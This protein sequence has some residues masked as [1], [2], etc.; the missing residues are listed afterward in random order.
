MTPCSDRQPS[1]TSVCIHVDLMLLEN[2]QGSISD[3]CLADGSLVDSI[4]EFQH[5]YDEL[6][7]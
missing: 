2:G 6:R 3:G 4:D 1:Q 7:K 5:M